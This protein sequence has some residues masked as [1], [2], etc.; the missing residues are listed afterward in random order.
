MR[1]PQGDL[2]AAFQFLK[3]SYKHERNQLSTRVDN[4]RERGNDFKLKEGR[5]RLDVRGKFFIESGGVLTGCPEVVAWHVSPMW[6]LEAATVQKQKMLLFASE[7][8]VV[9]MTTD[10]VP[11]PFPLAPEDS[12][13]G[14]LFCLF[15]LV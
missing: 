4:N 2:T 7:R 14:F 10:G 8:C 12:A 15:V 3:G 11:L 5:L 6:M 1:R 13:L 9:V